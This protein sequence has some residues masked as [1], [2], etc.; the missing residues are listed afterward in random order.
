VRF[1]VRCRGAESMLLDPV[2]MTRVITNLLVNARE[3]ISGSG[4]IELDVSVEPGRHN[5]GSRMTV[6]VR[7]TGQGMTE[8]FI[9]NS[10]FRPFAST[11]GS[12]L[13]IGLVQSKAIVEAHGGTISVES[14]AGRGTRFDIEVPEPIAD[15]KPREEDADVG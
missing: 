10:L 7:D 8:E 6:S 14:H 13:G 11:M 9:R 12:G 3:S 5:G 4:K 2:Q 15:A 1:D